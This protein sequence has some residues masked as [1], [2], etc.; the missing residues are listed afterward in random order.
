MKKGGLL[1]L[2]FG[3]TFSIIYLCCCLLVLLIVVIVVSLRNRYPLSSVEFAGVKRNY[4][5]RLPVNLDKTKSYP[6]LIGLHGGFGNARNYERDNLFEKLLTQNQ[7]FIGLYPFGYHPNQRLSLLAWNSGHIQCP[8]YYDSVSDSAFIN[9]LVNKTKTEYKIDLNKV[10]CVGHSNGAMMC[11]KTAGD[12]PSLFKTIVT[13][14][15]TIGGQI[16]K[17][18]TNIEITR[19]TNTISL[20]HI[21]GEKDVNVNYYGGLSAGIGSD[22]QGGRYDMSV[23]QSVSLFR[24]VNKCSNTFKEEFSLNRKIRLT[25]YDQ[26]INSTRLMSFSNQG[27]GWDELNSDISSEKFYG[28]YLAEAI[29]NLISN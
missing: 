3:G 17:N 16:N 20:L 9:F 11:Y 19:P 29:W 28:T 1:A 2:I 15:G 18:F 5:L 4:I 12:F 27:H 26:C 13:V 7:N 10:F 8:A 22:L 21:H 14:S 24:S 6:L 25:T 23:N